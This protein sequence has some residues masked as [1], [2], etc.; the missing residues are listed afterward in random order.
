MAKT[1]L[2]YGGNTFAFFLR[3][4]RGGAAKAV[5]PA[6]ATEMNTLIKE[7][8][9]GPLVVH[10]PYVMNLA[11]AKDDIRAKAEETLRD[12]LLRMNTYFPGNYYNFHPG[13]HVGQ[14]VETG[15]ARISESLNKIVP[16]DSKT[17]V[18]LETMAG[19]GSEIGRNFTEL[20][21][22]LDRLENPDR[23]GVCLDTCHVWD[24]GYDL[25]GHLDE[26]LDE[27][28]STVGL[29]RLY[30]VHLNDSMNVCGAHKDRHQKLGEGEIG[31][32][33]LKS[34][35]QHPA[36]QGRPFILETPN[37]PAGYKKEIEMVKTW[38]RE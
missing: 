31:R 21:D 16:P 26:V 12:D 2:D 4:P 25:A 3:S 38:I 15:I 28:E 8:H 7:N 6:D 13:A 14:G 10:A 20:R 1:M 35:V 22:I 23:F 17:I 30:A 9:F 5:D 27:F 24:A 37:K 32:K 29:D 11:S 19:K 36:L 33:T 18:L 34:V